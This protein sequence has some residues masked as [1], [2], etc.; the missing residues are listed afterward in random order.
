MRFS[1]V[2]FNIRQDFI[3]GFILRIIVLNDTFSFLRFDFYIYGIILCRWYIIEDFNLSGSLFIFFQLMDVYVVFSFMLILV[4]GFRI[5]YY[6][7]ER[8][9]VRDLFRVVCV[10]GDNDMF[11]QWLFYVRFS[12]F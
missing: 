4:V 9:V 6:I 5:F 12:Q 11:F 8:V 7:I 2:S 1:D 10:V 3:V